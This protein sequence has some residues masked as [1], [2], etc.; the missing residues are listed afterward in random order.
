MAI[1]AEL[2]DKEALQNILDNQLVIEKKNHLLQPIF[3]DIKSQIRHMSYT[4]EYQIIREY[5]SK[6]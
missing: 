4:P 5:F 3:R 6:R 1:Y 2:G